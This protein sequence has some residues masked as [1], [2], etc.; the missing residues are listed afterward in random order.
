MASERWR[1]LLDASVLVAG[2]IS[3]TGASAA[4]LDLAEAEE[5]FA[6]L[7][8]QVLTEADRVLLAKFPER[9]EPY[10]LFMKNL[11]PLL[12][13]DPPLSAVKAAAQV[14][15]PDDAVILAAAKQ[16]PVDY[17]VTLDVRHFTTP[18]VRAFL[19]VP[20]VTPAE[21]LDASRKFWERLS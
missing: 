17:L 16:E 3:R 19:P 4:I 20:I 21:F 6:V 7:T 18:Q 8:Q 1:V 11:N 5:I 2:T 9:I 10:R 12:L 14:I 15:H 13:D